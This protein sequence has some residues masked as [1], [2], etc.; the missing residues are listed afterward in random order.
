MIHSGVVGTQTGQAHEHQELKITVWDEDHPEKKR[1]FTLGW[2][3]FVISKKGY[4]VKAKWRVD[5]A[6]DHHDHCHSLS[7]SSSSFSSSNAS[8]LPA[9]ISKSNRYCT[10]KDII[11]NTKHGL[12]ST[13]INTTK[14]QPSGSCEIYTWQW[15][16]FRAPFSSLGSTRQKV[17]TQRKELPKWWMF[18][19]PCWLKRRTLPVTYIITDETSTIIRKLTWSSEG[20]LVGWWCLLL[21]TFTARPVILPMFRLQNGYFEVPMSWILKGPVEPW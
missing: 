1:E 9:N 15:W 13:H 7:S 11:T 4:Q 16:L 2:G 17:R 6:E 3:K 19:A 12:W 20:W 21:E 5:E 14:H 10:A 18:H 8:L